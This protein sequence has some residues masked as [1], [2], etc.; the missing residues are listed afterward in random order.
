MLIALGVVLGL[1][2][3]VIFAIWKAAEE[4]KAAVDQD[5]DAQGSR[6]QW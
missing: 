4:E 6:D 1:V 2:A 3:G 5:F